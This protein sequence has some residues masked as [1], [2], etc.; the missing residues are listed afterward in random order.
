MEIGGIDTIISRP[1]VCDDDIWGR[2]RGVV[3]KH[4]PD[5]T[6][7]YDHPAREMF[8][9]RDRAAEDFWNKDCG[10]PGTMVYVIMGEKEI[11]FVHDPEDRPLIQEIVE[12]VSAP[13]EP[14]DEFYR[15]LLSYL[16]HSRKCV[17][18]GE[19]L[20]MGYGD[21]H[22]WDRCLNC[23]EPSKGK[24]DLAGY[25]TD[26]PEPVGPLPPQLEVRDYPKGRRPWDKSHEKYYR[27]KL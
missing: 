16:P 15:L 13:Y 24:Y 21:G 23:D 10:P 22:V 17:D 12:V 5:Y 18:C 26:Y 8:L 3:L 6:V 7:E 27:W 9:Y 25:V 19:R 4:W 11:T 2:I 20:W 14:I 1:Q